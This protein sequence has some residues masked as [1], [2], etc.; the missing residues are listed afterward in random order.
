MEY[1]KKRYFDD[2]H[3][4]INIMD[5]LC[6]RFFITILGYYVARVNKNLFVN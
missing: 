6:S 2:H 3:F 5:Y 4:Y 1:K